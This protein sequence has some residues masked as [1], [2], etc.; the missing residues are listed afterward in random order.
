MRIETL[1]L[2]IYIY[3]FESLEGGNEMVK[4]Y[5]YTIISEKLFQ[6]IGVKSPFKVMKTKA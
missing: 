4:L 2:Y 6:L 1:I 3:N 5:N